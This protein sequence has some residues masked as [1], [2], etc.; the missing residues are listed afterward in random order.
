M[1]IRRATTADIE[2]LNALAAA[3]G[4]AKAP[5]YFET[6]LA[7][8]DA[9]RRALYIIATGD[10]DAG[11]GMLN[12]HPQYSLYKRL[13]IPEIQ[14]LNVIPA[15]RRMGLARALIAHC[16]TT[17]RAQ[18]CTQMGISVGLYSDYGAAQR[19]YV[20]LGYVPDGFGVTYDRETVRPGE[21]RPVDDNLCLMMVK[22]L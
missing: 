9:G 7:E 21:F 3:N 15:H 2:S 6:C 5:D 4:S 1:I 13:G 19:L 12:W 10:A 17:A 18:S 11:Y 8:Q 22:D 14:D 16:E 20:T